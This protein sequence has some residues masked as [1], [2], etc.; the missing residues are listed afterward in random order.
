MCVIVLTFGCV[1]FGNYMYVDIISMMY[2]EMHEFSRPHDIHYICG[3]ILTCNGA[4]HCICMGT[5]H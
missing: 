1:C 3:M 5:L 2:G 4:L